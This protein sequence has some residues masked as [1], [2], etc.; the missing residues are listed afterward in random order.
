MGRA[1]SALLALVL[2]IGIAGAGAAQEAEPPVLQSPIL[3]LDQ[4]RL[5]AETLWGLR[6]AERIEAASMVLA[7]ENRRIEAELTAEE[8]KLTEQRATMPVDEFRKAAEAFDAKVTD[9]RREQDVKARAIGQLHD[10]ERQRFY[11]AALP[12]MTE[13]L[14]AHQA[15]AVLDSRAIFLAADAIDVTDELI[16]RIDVVLGAGEDAPAPEVTS[17]GPDAGDGN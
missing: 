15:V 13:V 14:R 9:L 6:A 3:T 5:F 4:D 17:T 10:A 7:A 1:R 8:R 2:G 11:T 12:V 16:A